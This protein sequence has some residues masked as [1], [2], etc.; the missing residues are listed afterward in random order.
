M[1]CGN[2]IDKTT[3]GNG[4]WNPWMGTE[5]LQLLADIFFEV[6]K[7]VEVAGWNSGS[8]G[9]ILDSSAQ[10]LFAG[11]HQSAI[12]MIDH[13]E[14]F[15]TQEIVRYEQGAQGVV[16]DDAASVADDVRITRL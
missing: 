9:T 14:F 1:P 2:F 8:P 6:L 16:R 10:I 4:F 12:G 15:G 13:H 5:F 7:C 11:I 3:N